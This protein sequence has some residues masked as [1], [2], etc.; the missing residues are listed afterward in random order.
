MR[1]FHVLNSKDIEAPKCLDERNGDYFIWR[2]Y[3]R[4]YIEVLHPKWVTV[5]DAIEGYQKKDKIEGIEIEKIAKK[6]GQTGSASIVTSQF[7]HHFKRAASG[8]LKSKLIMMGK[9]RAMDIYREIYW[10]NNDR[11]GPETITLGDAMRHP[12]KA[13]NL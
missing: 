8:T 1:K 9:N 2:K 12:D 4:D 7:L 5:I 13:K 10:R 6:V 11:M 3:F